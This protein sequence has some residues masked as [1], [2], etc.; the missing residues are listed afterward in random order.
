[1]ESLEPEQERSILGLQSC[2]RQGNRKDHFQ[3]RSN[4]CQFADNRSTENSPSDRNN[5]LTSFPDNPSIELPP[6]QDLARQVLP[7]MAAASKLKSEVVC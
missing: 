6:V 7:T 4:R 3:V 5:Q 1:M 2:S